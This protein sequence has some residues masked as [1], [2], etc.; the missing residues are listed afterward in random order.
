MNDWK[1][2]DKEEQQRRK[3]YLQQEKTINRDTL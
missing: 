1:N 3:C 2:S